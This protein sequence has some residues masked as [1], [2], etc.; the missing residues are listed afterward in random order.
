MA[1]LELAF[2]F[3]PSNPY[4]C[5][6]RPNRNYERFFLRVLPETSGV[7]VT[8]FG[9]DIGVLDLAPFARRFDA[10]LFFDCVPWGIPTVRGEEKITVPKVCMAGDPHSFSKRWGDRTKLEWMRHFRFDAYF[11]QHAPS[12]FYKHAPAEM[13]YWWLPLGVDEEQYGGECPPL[14]ARRRDKVLLTGVL[15]GELYRMRTLLSRLPQVHYIAPGSYQGMRY[16]PRPHDGPGYRNLLHGWA[17]A[18]AS[19]YSFL[20]KHLEIPAAGCLS[21]AH[22]EDEALDFAELRGTDRCIEIRSDT[23]WEQAL[24]LDGDLARYQTIADAGRDHVLGMFTHRHQA[25]KLVAKIKELV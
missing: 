12:Y 18:I 20:C 9:Q 16:E 23:D 22:C 2:V 1:K 17:Y 6:L 25:V 15:G 3:R 8:M 21:F 19:G 4:L 10:W 24:R 14:S 11:F 13:T 7:R 5:G